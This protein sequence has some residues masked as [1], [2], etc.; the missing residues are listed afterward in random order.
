MKRVETELPELIDA[1]PTRAAPIDPALI[2]VLLQRVDDREAEM[3][4]L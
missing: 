3:L 1:R 2:S 4:L